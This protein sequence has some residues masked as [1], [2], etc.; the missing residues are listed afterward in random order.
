[1]PPAARQIGMMSRQQVHRGLVV[2]AGWGLLG[3][4]LAGCGSVAGS[5]P[6]DGGASTSAG[7]GGAIVAGA[8]APASAT[9]KVG[10]AGVNQATT[11]TISRF[12]HLVRPSG[13]L[14]VINREPALVRALFRDF[15]GAVTH[16]RTGSGVLHCPVDLGTDYAGAFY[17]GSRLLARYS[18]AASGCQQVGIT[19]GSTTRSTLVAGSAAA[20]APHLATDWAAVLDAAKPVSVLPASQVNPGGPNIPAS[21]SSPSQ[22]N[23][24]GPNN[25]G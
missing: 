19:V 5:T 18:Y 25:P 7:S 2:A 20:A 17:D 24:G 3:A 21:V 12:T 16:P 6:A 9:P 11:V 13:A 14:L 22:V 15:C 1:M 8:A 10:C 4:L 23:P